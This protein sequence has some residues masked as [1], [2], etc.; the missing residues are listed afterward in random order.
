MEPGAVPTTDTAA[1]LSLLRRF[2]HAARDPAMLSNPPVAAAFCILRAFGLIAPLPYWFLVALVFTGGTIAI[3]STAVLGAKRRALPIA[4]YCFISTGVVCVVAYATGWGPILSVGFVFAAGGAVSHFGA[5]AARWVMVW[6]VLWMSLGQMAIA[7]DWA[8]TLIRQPLVQGLAGLSLL[9]TLLTISLLGREAFRREMAAAEVLQSERRFKALVSN[10]SDIIMVVGTEGRLKYVSPAF[11]RILGFSPLPYYE[12]S[13][14]D[15][16]HPD[17]L[18]RL[19]L[20]VG[21]ASEHPEQTLVTHLRI[22]DAGGVW[23]NFEVSIADRMDDPDVQGI[24]GNLHDNTDLLEAHARFRSAFE[25]APTGMA[26]ISLDGVVQRANRAYGMI[27]GRAPADMIGLALAELVHPDERAVTEAEMRQVAADDADGYEMEQR[28]LHADGREVWVM[29][30]VS[31]V[32]DSVGHPQYLVGQIQDITEQHSMRERLAHAAIHDPLTGLPNRV[33]FMDRLS[34]AMSRAERS[35]CRVAV[36]F[37]DLDR[38]KLV[39]DGLGHA[40]GDDL[41]QAV[42]E[43]IAGAVRAEDTVARFGGDEFTIL[44][45]DL[46][47]QEDA[48]MVARRVLDSLQ[49]PFELAGAPVYVTASIGVVVAEAGSSPTSMLRDADAAMYRAKDAGRGR[50]EIF[51]GRSHAQ[52]LEHLRVITTLHEALAG[53]QFVLHYQPIVDLTDGTTVAMEALVR[54]QHPERGLLSPA[55][56]VPQAEECGLIVPIGAWVMQEAAVQCARW[57]DKRAAVGMVPMEMQVNISPRQL[58]DADFV[59]L[60]HNCMTD[61]HME[62][63][64]LCL[65]ITEGTLMGDEHLA[66]Q[67]LLAVR[68]LGVRISIDDFGTGYSSL[69]RLKRFPIDSLK[70]DRTFVNGLGQDP[71]DSVIA[72]AVVT[73]AHSLGL[74]AVAE[75]VESE[76][77][78]HELRNMGCDRVQGFLI[79]E[80]RAAADIDAL[81]F[82]P[83]LPVPVGA[84]L[85]RQLIKP[86]TRSRPPRPAAPA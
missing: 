31:C 86:R 40:T 54:W 35:G 13:A 50:V 85:G 76:L 6:T 21:R 25:D 1:R 23:R 27:V 37:L 36:A 51:D 18:Q 3:M 22:Q 57:N 16:V 20:E 48:V 28:L 52:A 30:H 29:N 77:I 62:R 65:E 39:N 45:E 69:S 78:L 67:Q 7:L 2:L 38:F 68:A 15:F 63:G 32:K 34:M 41:L 8:P 81:L 75:G 11:E 49:R 59:D 24:V 12:R 79:S 53:G 56:F 58:G 19:N 5:K 4:T 83:L 9:G 26:V 64:L 14:G 74:L 73:L 44:W 47:G 46:D 84:A 10:S 60:V 61:N 55:H 80:P 82:E 42:A 72:S 70:V 43:R 17:D 66:T 33:L 71:D